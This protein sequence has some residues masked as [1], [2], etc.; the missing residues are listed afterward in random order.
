MQ[1]LI[2]IIY[3]SRSIFPSSDAFGGLDPNVARILAKSRTNNR[4][5][6]LVGVLY[7]G[8]GCFFQ[9]LEGEQE[10]VE[11]LYQTLLEDPRH[12][13]LKLLSRKEIS[14]RSFPDW[15]MKF[16]GI[17]TEM[18]RLLAGYGYKSFDPYSFS[19]E[20]T[21]AVMGLLHAAADPTESSTIAP[22]SN[23]E[24]ITPHGDQS[25]RWALFISIFA[26]LVATAAMLIAAGII[27]LH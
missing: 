3:I 8:D 4:K 27:K 17:G 9:C 20:V 18:K 25:V 2:Q 16:V 10:A 11:K 13:D 1:N 6:G 21:Q 5:E 26:L 15:S 24:V 23:T 7:F 22:T 12:K 19:P 14:E